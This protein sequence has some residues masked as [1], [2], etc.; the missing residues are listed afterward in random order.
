MEG[1]A[2][3]VGATGQPMDTTC[4]LLICVIVGNLAHPWWV[5]R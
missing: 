2:I 4:A 5:S 3:A 1:E